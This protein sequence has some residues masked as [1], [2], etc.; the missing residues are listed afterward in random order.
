MLLPALE[1]DSETRKIPASAPATT[2]IIT[3][4]IMIVFEIAFVFDIGEGKHSSIL[5]VVHLQYVTLL[6]EEIIGFPEN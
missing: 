5:G 1:P 2:R 3:V 6:R 4:M